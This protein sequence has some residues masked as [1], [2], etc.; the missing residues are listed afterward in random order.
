M[1]KNLNNIII[2]F[3]YK[4]E[5]ESLE[6]VGIDLIKDVEKKI[7]KTLPEN[8]KKLYLIS[9]GGVSNYD[10]VTYLV[11]DNIPLHS[12]G[13]INDFIETLKLDDTPKEV[14]IFAGESHSWFALDY[15]QKDE[16]SIIYYDEYEDVILNVADNFDQFLELLRE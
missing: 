11:D 8:L 12:F 4:D 7:G 13:Q 2:N 14:V 1:T 6:G 16:P 9:N 5:S 10:Q 3:W 15:R